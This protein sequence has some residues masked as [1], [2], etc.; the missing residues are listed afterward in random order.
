MSFQKRLILSFIFIL[1]ISIVPITM[2]SLKVISDSIDLWVQQDTE[3][4][5]RLAIERI[6]SG[7]GQLKAKEVL[8]GY[9]QLKALKEPIKME[10]IG[11]S[12]FLAII[13]FIVAIILAWLFILWLTNPLKKLTYATQQ[14]AAG[15]LDVKLK[16]G[17]SSEIRR[18]IDSFN[19]MQ[20][21]LKNSQEELKKT[22]RR[23]A[24]QQVAQ[25]LAHEIKNPLT[26][27]QLSIERIK[28]KYKG[29]DLQFANILEEDSK[30]ILQEIDSLRRL[31]DEFSQFARM[32]ELKLKKDAINP[33][34][35]SLTA[36][37][38][39]SYPQIAFN[40]KLEKD[41]PLIL[42]DSDSLKRALMNIIKNAI[43]AM[44][45]GGTLEI[46]NRLENQAVIIEI[47]DTGIGI[48]DDEIHYLFEPHYS[49]KKEGIGLGLAI[50]REIIEGHK[51][52]IEVES[53]VGK[54][55]T[56]RLILPI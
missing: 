45:N 35:A 40:L 41:L 13:V 10:I 11:F 24:W 22:S 37:Y 42:V 36:G 4:T 5:L 12:I 6:E 43:E 48:S 14:V 7:K 38:S 21:S 52:K 56:F 32:P 25:T 1:L 30:L 26:P 33:I 23:A 16:V 34:I 19:Q 55:A 39:A 49:K 47:Q 8:K 18:L 20:E 50:A 17:G 29:A 53:N 15:E 28:R 44:P 54:G 51:G 3:D 9:L 31:T 2:F 27:I 46:K